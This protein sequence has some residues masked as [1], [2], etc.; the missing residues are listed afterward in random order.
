M[1]VKKIVGVAVV[2]SLLICVPIFGSPFW[3]KWPDPRITPAISAVTSA[4]L[5]FGKVYPYLYEPFL[6]VVK[7]H[8]AEHIQYNNSQDLL[9]SNAV[10]TTC[11]ECV[12]SD[13]KKRESL[14]PIKEV[15]FEGE[16]SFNRKETIAEFRYDLLIA[17]ASSLIRSFDPFY[18]KIQ[19]ADDL[20][21]N[22]TI[23]VQ[24]TNPANNSSNQFI[25]TCRNI[26]FDFK[27]AFYVNTRFYLMESVTL[28][29]AVQA[30]K[31]G[32]LVIATSTKSEMSIHLNGSKFLKVDPKGLFSRS[33]Q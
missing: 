15:A 5:T 25:I 28:A 17:S 22:G 13:C 4:V 6:C 27:E 24:T 3:P 2:T 26:R 1:T 9:V 12:S 31:S 23:H 10:V 20:F 18:N 30:L 33:L 7:V 14:N 32:K 16:G 21:V 19:I 11:P 29:D 8:F